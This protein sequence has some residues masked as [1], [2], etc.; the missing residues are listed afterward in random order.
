MKRLSTDTEY[1]QLK[2][3][4]EALKAELAQNPDESREIRKQKEEIRKVLKV[5]ENRKLQD[6][7][8]L[9]KKEEMLKKLRS[10]TKADRKVFFNISAA[11]SF[12]IDFSSLSEKER[13]RL[14][15]RKESLIEMMK[16]GMYIRLCN[17]PSIYQIRRDPEY[18]DGMPYI[19]SVVFGDIP[20][21]DIAL[22]IEKYY[23]E[24]E[25]SR[26][27]HKV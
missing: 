13:N 26:T 20:V 10:R 11:E 16:K 18:L 25:L 21:Q 23:Y 3:E 17:D 14:A 19:S 1:W 8:A 2:D 22:L 5:Y 6:V 15:V 12:F 4:Y 24:S 7:K 9:S 27:G